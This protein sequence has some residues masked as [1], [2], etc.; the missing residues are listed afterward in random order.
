MGALQL[1]L[2]QASAV[3]GVSAKELQN[4]VQF[5]VLKPKRRAGLC[6]FDRD[7]LLEA[8]VALYLKQNLQ[9][10]TSRLSELV[11]AFA[12]RANS[13]VPERPDFL[14]FRLQPS[15]GPIAIEVKIPFRKLSEDL[16]QRLRLADLYKDLPRGRKRPGWKREFVESLRQAAE[17]LGVVS[18]EEILATIRE[19]RK[20]RQKPDIT[21]VV[22]AQEAST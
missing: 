14:V 13:F 18:L 6:V 8:L 11:R 10:S 4:F 1:K 3:L 16:E 15:T 17:Q 5:G 22:E 20:E 19:Y 21:V 7:T 12:S 2:K 9:T